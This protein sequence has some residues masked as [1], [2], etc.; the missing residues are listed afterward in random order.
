MSDDVIRVLHLEDEPLDSELAQAVL[1]DAGIA[2]QL[3]RVDTLQD[4]QSALERRVYSL[5]L[6]DYTHPLAPI[7]STRLRFVRETRPELPFVFVSGTIGE[8]RAIQALKMGRQRLRPQAADGPVCPKSCA[9]A[10]GEA[11]EA[12]RRK[13]AEQIA[14]TQRRAIATLSRGRGPSE[15]LNGIPQLEGTSGRLRWRRCTAWRPGPSRE[16]LRPGWT[17]PIQRTEPA[18]KIT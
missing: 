14:S 4:L 12:A 8:E 17:S 13:A 11:Q 6:S 2:V 3:D 10:L 5:V 7:H 1:S 9:G 18:L 15:A 16:R